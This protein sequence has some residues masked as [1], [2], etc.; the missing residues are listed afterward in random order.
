M[1]K[2]TIGIDPGVK[3]GWAVKQNG[4][5]TDVSTLTIWQFFEAIEDWNNAG[6]IGCVVVEDARKC[7]R[8][9]NDKSAARAQGAG[10]VKTLS[11]QFEQFL[12]DKEIPYKMIAPMKGAKKL[13][14][15]M[16]QRITGYREETNQH[17]RD[18]IMIAWNN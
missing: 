6:M 5:I 3:V 16:V 1:T 2:A 18:A 4:E 10:F 9:F 14:R 8:W 7:G 12:I 13:D 17:S 11:G 15:S